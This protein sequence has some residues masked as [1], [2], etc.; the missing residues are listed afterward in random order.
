MKIKKIFG[1]SVMA[2]GIALLAGCT[3]ETTQ[4]NQQTSSNN[5]Q[6]PTKN[7]LNSVAA[8]YNIQLGLGYMAQGDMQRAKTKLL[9]ALQQAPNSAPANDAMAVF[10]ERVGDV[11]QAKQFY[12]RG[13]QLAPGKGAE[14]NNYGTFLCRQGQYA[15]SDNYF[16]GA[17]KDPSYLNVAEAYE[18]AGLCASAVPNLVKAKQYF[19]RA[20]EQDPRRATS[21]LELAEINYKQNNYNAAQSYLLAYQK[22]APETARS[23]WLSYRLAKQQG[24]SAQQNAFAS[25]LK[26]QFSTSREYKQYT[27]RN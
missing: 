6:S 4:N 12:L 18:N 17:V 20:I 16:L 21:M 2:A 19:L 22:I 26:S 9:L 23:L 13:L 25:R 3:T 5:S 8:E 1:I 10:Q 11:N 27:Q 7:G 24:N 14:L 15:E